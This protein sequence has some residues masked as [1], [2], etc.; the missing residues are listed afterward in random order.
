MPEPERFELLLTKLN[1]PRLAAHLLPRTRLYGLLDAGLRLPLTLVSAPAGYGKSTLVASWL[2]TTDHAKA[3][4]SFDKS[5]DSLNVFLRYVVGAIR[6]AVPG[7]LEAARQMLEV[8]ERPLVSELVLRL[9]NDLETLDRD[10]ILVLD[11]LH[12][13]R[14]SEVYD[15]LDQMLRHPPRRLHLVILSRVDPALSLPR[16]RT[17]AQLQEIR[18]ADLQFTTDETSAMLAQDIGRT[19]EPGAIDELNRLTEGWALGLHLAALSLRSQPDVAGF[20]AQVGGSGLR[21]EEFLLEEVL[22][23]QPP[24]YQ[25]C[26]LQT[27]VLDRFCVELCGALCESGVGATSI[28]GDDFIAWVRE[29]NL[30]LLSLDEN[31]Q[32]YRYHHLFRELLAQRLVKERGPETVAQLHLRAARWFEDRGHIDAAL[33]HYLSSGRKDEAVSLVR[34]H[35]HTAMNQERWDVVDRW[36]RFLPAELSAGDLELLILRGYSLENRYRYGELLKLLEDIEKLIATETS[37]GSNNT[38]QAELDPLLA[39]RHYF[40]SDPEGA[41][42]LVRRAL[43]HLPA[44]HQSV[45]GF[46]LVLYG[47]IQQMRG[48]WQAGVT[49]LLRELENLP[50]RGTTLHG[51]ILIGLAFIHW[52]EADLEQT[53]HYAHE[54]LALGKQY[55]LPESVAFGQ[56]FVGVSHYEMG[57]SGT[58]E[59]ALLPL[60]A[61]RPPVNTNSWIYCAF[62]CALIRLERGDRAGAEEI[63]AEIARFGIAAR[64]PELVALASAMEAELAVRL[65]RR[66]AAARWAD[67]HTPKV[68]LPRWRCYVPESTYLKHLLLKGAQDDL[69]QAADLASRQ[70]AYLDKIHNKR[71]LSEFL[72]LQAVIASRTADEDGAR[73]HLRRAL[74]TA[75]PGRCLR[76]FLDLGADLHRLLES[77]ADDPNLAGFVGR[78]LAALTAAAPAGRLAAPRRAAAPSGFDDLTDREAEVL[79]LLAH[80]LSNQEIAEHLFISPVT[81]KRHTSNIYRKLDVNRRRDAVARARALGLL[82]KS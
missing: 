67:S 20:L 73:N 41:L 38:L 62:T 34:R 72:A 82:R 3:W 58:A 23:Q 47:F 15:F 35:R 56:Y 77:F 71:F 9:V 50:G 75:Q 55:E 52:M 40:A 28:G 80:R 26:L 14:D 66:A 25:E 76:P 46:A 8:R 21:A 42:S 49:V 10:V 24:E 61:D 5:D 12:M 4:V 43:Q 30:F 1:A 60:F 64:N 37:A 32:W 45:R 36:L 18:L 2:E 79:D 63:S 6:R 69:K 16:L 51:R 74:E 65:E 33:Q 13:V 44:E 27:A 29:N 68:E 70:S 7:S 19:L 17:A 81:V 39:V 48:D 59:E 11:D 22:L 53:A 31:R 57:D 78:I 54:L